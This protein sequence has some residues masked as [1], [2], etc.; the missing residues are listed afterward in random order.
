[1]SAGNTNPRVTAWSPSRYE[2]YNACPQK[3][4]YEVIQK[5]CPSCF[6]GK[7]TGGFGSPAICDTCGNI[8]EQ[9]APLVRGSEVGESVNQYLLKQTK[10]VCAEAKR[11]PKIARLL[12]DLRKVEHGLFVEK[13]IYL[14][15]DWRL[16]R[17]A[18]KFSPKVWFRGR[19][20]CLVLTEAGK[21][22]PVTA[23]VIDWK[24]GGIDK[25]TGA[26]RVD[27]AKYDDQLS[28]YNVGVLCAYPGV[29]KSEAMLAFLDCGPRHE[30]FVERPKLNM[31]RDMLPAAQAEWERKVAPMFADDTFSPRPGDAC[32]FCAF[33]RAG[34]GPCPY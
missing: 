9:G 16:M 7:L 29:T 3:F 14:D 18:D 13:E 12:T 10:T 8:V 15:K 30:P 31:T 19:L 25:R 28:T 17:D 6:K 20:D 1:M 24:T 27:D 22:G 21:K 4:L 2:K 23:K 11:H 32:R 5:L 33:K 26:V 34:D